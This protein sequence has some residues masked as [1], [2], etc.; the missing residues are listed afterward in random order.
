MQHLINIFKLKCYQIRLFIIKHMAVFVWLDPI[1]RLLQV[2]QDIYGMMR[3]YL[4]IIFC[5]IVFTS[6]A[7]RGI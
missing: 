2:P 6:S 3:G 1:L 4:W 5:G 7:W